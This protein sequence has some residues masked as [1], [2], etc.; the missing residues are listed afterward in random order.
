[1][2]EITS[3]VPA[4]PPTEA[5]TPSPAVAPT[6]ASGSVERRL[7]LWPA[8]VILALQWLLMTV[9]PLIDRESILAMML[10][11]LGA[12]LLGL[13]GLT[14]WWLFASRLRWRDRWL[15]I[16][17]CFGLGAIAYAFN[18]PTF[19]LFPIIMFALPVLITAG[20][21]WLVLAQWLSWPVRR[22]GLV[23]V[24]ILVWGHF[25]L[26][27]FD[28]VN[29]SFAPELSYRWV[30]SAQE[31]FEADRAGTVAVDNTMPL[32][33]GPGDWPGFRGANRDGRRSGV[34]IT[35]AWDQHPPKLLWKQ[36]VGAGWSSFAVV[37]NRL[38]TQ[39][40][41]DKDHEAVVCCAVDSGKQIWV[42]QSAGR[43]SEKLG[44]DG[45]RAT[46]TFHEGKI[47]ALGAT[48]IL[49]C[50]DA[51]T[52]R[53]LW[54]HDVLADSGA[55]LPM[56]GFSSSPLVVQGVVTIFTGAEGG[57]SVLGYDAVTGKLAWFA[58]EGQLSYCSM[59]PARLAGV[60][61]VLV[62]TENGLTAFEPARGAVLW[63]FSFPGQMP[64][65]VCQPA[66]LTDS[67]VL[68]GAGSLPGTKR[69]R[70]G[71][72]TSGWTT[73]EVWTTRAIKPYF[74][75]LVVHGDH[76]Y[77]FDNDQL[78]CVS[79]DGGKGKWRVPGY[80][81]GQVLLLADQGHLLVLTEE[82]A[83]A[84]VEATPTAHKELGRFQAI[85]GKTWNHPV[86]AN[87][88]LFVRNSEWAACF[89]VKDDK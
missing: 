37:G 3:H 68:V 31:R 48:G 44:G 6:A 14:L 23:V 76:L 32:V 13:L 81:N 54:S 24:F 11:K 27:R 69:V 8:V 88:N 50:L 89:E 17:A 41:W 33:L 77:G 5:S 67:D 84:L 25:T 12:P 59:Q 16:V 9:P 39:M 29:G 10:A 83:V 49:N 26:V 53:P 71:H 36:R 74:N 15:G 87:G 47:Y 34:R 56:W 61:Q 85:E 43:F 42:H 18:H 46:P 35:T 78:T 2:S 28:G 20:V 51:A 66:V 62:L 79:L 72:G 60:E 57:K 70:V 19:D 45:P 82:G 4:T 21:L 1:M 38:F 55:K 64:V 7:R 65:R 30:P 80:G 63:N 75:D 73:E 86:V 58:G 22:A 40:Q 52:G